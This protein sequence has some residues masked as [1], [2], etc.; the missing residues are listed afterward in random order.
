M[1]A[2]I[3]EKFSALIIREQIKTVEYI[4]C[5][6]KRFKTTVIVNIRENS[7]QWPLLQGE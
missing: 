4:F 1:L 2:N 7:V 5:S 6:I 3:F